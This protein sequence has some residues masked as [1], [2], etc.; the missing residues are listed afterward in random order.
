MAPTRARQR[1]ALLPKE[2]GAY[3]ELIF[4][5]ITALA[6]GNLRMAQWFLAFAAVAAFLA[7]ES[8]LVI[9]GNRG[10]RAR[11][12]LTGQ[13]KWTSTILLL[14]ACTTA[15]LG[16]WQAPVATLRAMLIPLLLTVL[17]IPLILSHHEKTL[18]GELL[19]ALILS[20]AL[21]PVAR[22]GDVGFETATVAGLVW[23][24]VF[25]FET[26]TVRAVKAHIR[27]DTETGP[28]AHAIVVLGLSLAVIAFLLAF[29]RKPLIVPIA[30]IFPAALAGL[31]CVWL[32][33][34]PRHLRTL[35]WVL[36]T[37]DVIALAL[38]TASSG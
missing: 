13:A 30:A 2:H 27:T 29:N 33:V 16:L 24:A 32:R 21:I 34:H 35:G 8:V 10:S 37:C 17:L 19:V 36:V 14:I 6:L 12:R 3:A 23:F 4:P 18:A 15:A 28:L 26:L 5:L 25:S 9:V 38:L 1:W 11:S 31:A 20:S 22:A 7:H